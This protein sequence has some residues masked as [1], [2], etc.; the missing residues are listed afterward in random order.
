[1]NYGMTILSNPGTRSHQDPFFGKKAPNP[2]SPRSSS[3]LFRSFPRDF[4]PAALLASALSLAFVVVVDSANAASVSWTG[5]DTGGDGISWGETQN[6]SSGSIPGADD[7]V[8]IGTGKTVNINAGAGTIKSLACSGTLMANSGLTVSGTA[9]VT[10]L[11]IS[12]GGI[13]FNGTSTVDNLSMSSGSVGGSGDLTVKEPFAWTGGYVYGSGGLDLQKGMDLSG[14]SLKK[15]SGRTINNTKTVTWSGSGHWEITG[16]AVFDNKA[17]GILDIQGSAILYNS[18]TTSSATFKNAGIVKKT[19][20]G[21]TTQFKADVFENNGGTVEVQAGTV[22]FVEGDAVFSGATMSV[23][24]GATLKFTT[25]WIVSGTL[26]GASHCG[27]PATCARWRHRGGCCRGHLPI[28][29]QGVR[30]GWRVY[31]HSQ[32]GWRQPRHA[33]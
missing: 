24:D 25:T 17:G 6:W 18:A 20:D 26:S 16:N 3:G 27:H 8:S 15:L 9:T 22:D 11:T 12:G 29:K 10:T 1:M 23:A 7:D 32:S 19:A 30:M 4:R 14:S 5:T 21:G 13:A 31:A 33:V 2:A 28:R